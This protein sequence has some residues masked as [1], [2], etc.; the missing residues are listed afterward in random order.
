MDQV[1]HKTALSHR[2]CSG[3]SKYMNGLEG[4]NGDRE[5][6]SLGENLHQIGH[7]TNLQ[8]QGRPEVVEQKLKPV[9]PA[10]VVDDLT[11]PIRRSGWVI[12][13]ADGLPQ[14]FQRRWV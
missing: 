8:L 7:I 2:R 9:L 5:R 11:N 12:L 6:D 1:R 13:A 10:M 14:R 3:L 4:K